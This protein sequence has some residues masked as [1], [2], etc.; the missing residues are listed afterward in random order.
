MRINDLIKKIPH[1]ILAGE[2]FLN[3]EIKSGYCCDLLSRVMAHGPRN[4]IW[5]TVQTHVN[6]IAIATLLDISCIIIPEDI[7]VDPNTI[8]KAN[9]EE[10]V[11]ISSPLTAFELAGRLY[12]MGVGN[13]K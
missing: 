9:E 2:E 6:I 4:G 10:V 1:T 7:S 12:E 5:I 3:R 8:A 11:V 13:Q